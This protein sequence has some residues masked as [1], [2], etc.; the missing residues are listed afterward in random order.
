[1]YPGFESQSIR[2]L[3]QKLAVWYN[4]NVIYPD[5]VRLNL[6]YLKHYSFIK[7]IEMIFATVLGR[8]IEYNNEII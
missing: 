4:D 5:K 7:D 2:N 6:Y 1:M 8:H 3:I